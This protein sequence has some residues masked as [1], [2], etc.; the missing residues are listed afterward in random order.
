MLPATTDTLDC[1]Y[2]VGRIFLRLLLLPKFSHNRPTR[3]C[4]LR[5]KSG[6]LIVTPRRHVGYI[7]HELELQEI[8]RDSK[9]ENKIDP[10]DM[11]FNEAK[12][13]AL[14][15]EDT[16]YCHLYK[17]TRNSNVFSAS[18]VLPQ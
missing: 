10:M 3:V 8:H 16:Q 14:R 18:T 7:K 6:H 13:S 17:C 1:A 9:T 4:V 12:L 5:N 15:E 2:K 11:N